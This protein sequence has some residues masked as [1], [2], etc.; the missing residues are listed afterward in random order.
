LAG[1]RENAHRLGLTCVR[2]VNP[3]ELDQMLA[4]R[5]AIDWVLIDAPCS[6]TGVLA[7]RPEAKYRVSPKGLARLQG[8]QLGLLEQAAQLAGKHTRLAYSTCSIEPEENEDLIT[9][10]RQGQPQWQLTQAHRALP[11][12]D[13][14]PGYWHDGGYWALLEC[15]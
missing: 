8:V 10:F 15:S 13:V 12:G 11:S 3:G 4:D 6:N 1:I 2:T 5:H 14:R 9:R 7:R